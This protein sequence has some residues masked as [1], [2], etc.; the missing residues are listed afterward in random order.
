MSHYL[1]TVCY[2]LP[3]HRA[4][5]LPPSRILQKGQS[6][7]YCWDL[8]ERQT[9]RPGPDNVPVP[10]VS[11]ET[12]II[13]YTDVRYR[14]ED[15]WTALGDNGI[16]AR[17]T[18]GTP[19][20]QATE[21]LS[22]TIYGN[23]MK[24]GHVWLIITGA[25]GCGKTSTLNLFQPLEE[26]RVISYQGQ[27]R[28][29]HIV[30]RTKSS[31]VDQVRTGGT[32]IVRDFGALLA[33]GIQTFRKNMQTLREVYDGDI[34]I[35]KGRSAIR[36]RGR[37]GWI[38]AGTQ[39]C[40]SF[41]KSY[42]DLG[43]RFLWYRMESQDQPEAT[44]ATISHLPAHMLA[45]TPPAS[46]QEVPNPYVPEIETCAQLAYSLNMVRGRREFWRRA[47]EQYRTL[48]AAMAILREEPAVTPAI[49]KE[50]FRL[51]VRGAPDDVYLYL[52][53]AMKD[54]QDSRELMK[55]FCKMKR[56][57]QL[58]FERIHNRLLTTRWL[59]EN[60]SGI[61][62]PADRLKPIMDLIGW[63]PL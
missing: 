62:Q 51:A 8:W 28:T 10:D 2:K 18:A 19:D 53:M 23:M 41:R 24:D 26:H 4:Y 59:Y 15:V 61:I 43:E 34:V 20:P 57:G 13:H 12:R 45:I 25:S 22:A 44:F 14:E 16:M 29:S 39:V 42:Q 9:K 31:L 60:R 32:I 58:I 36:W 49:V 52:M 37:I 3:S 40:H 35:A 38:M 54:V 47:F 1:A 6:L 48:A 56:K 46:V 11:H 21:L 7:Y 30:S 55:R 5:R 50:I 63:P 33:N 27:F 17:L